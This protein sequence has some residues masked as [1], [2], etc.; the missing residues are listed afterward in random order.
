MKKF[1]I[2]IVLFFFSL[3]TSAQRMTVEQYIET[4]K[5]FAIDEMIKYGI[6]ASIT[7]AQGI[8]ESEFGNSR[9][10]REGNNHF[11]IKCKDTWTGPTIHQSDDAPNECFRKYATAADS[12]RDHSEF[13]RTRNHYAFL[14]DIDQLDYKAWAQGLKKAGYATNPRYPVILIDNIEKHNLQQYSIIALNRKEEGGDL[15]FIATQTSFS[16]EEDRHNKQEAASLETGNQP[17]AYPE[18]VFEINRTK[19][20]YAKAGTAWIAIASNYNVSLHHLFDFNEIKEQEILLNDQ[21]VFL[22]RK[23]KKGEVEFHTAKSGETLYSIAQAEGIRL[24]SLLEYNYFKSD[25]QIPKGTKLYL[26]D[27]A[28]LNEKLSGENNNENKAGGK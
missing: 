24:E 23:R 25:V 5:E 3:I 9:L 12:Y 2:I 11:G 4:Y 14:F 1:T 16:N 7:L 8:L 10:A 13:L 27:K 17:P 19:V 15:A 26:Q 18:G 6:P 22:G 21:L 20:I 28:P